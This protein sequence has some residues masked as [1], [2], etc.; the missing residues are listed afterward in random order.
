MRASVRSYA[1]YWREAFRLPGVNPTVLARSPRFPVRGRGY[2]DAALE[3]GRGVIL[4]LPH[5]GNWDMAGVWLLHHYGGFSTVAERLRP[6]SLFRRF[7]AYREGLGF[8]VFA[9]TGGERPPY[10]LLASRLRQNRIVCLLSERDLS[11]R[12]IP[13]SFFGERARMAAG[14]ATLAADTGAT[15][16]PVHA[17]YND[18]PQGEGWG[19]K[20]DPPIDISGGAESATQL[21]A[22]RFAANIAAHPADWHMLQPLWTADL[23]G[24]D[25]GRGV[26]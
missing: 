20:A 6:D 26:L 12:G 16:L 5:S 8:E 21:L 24:P 23:F 15:L 2:I 11:G 7:V 9:L 25:S 4:A 18:G 13:V 22:D 3:R 14:P 19:L 1:R 17:W 10:E